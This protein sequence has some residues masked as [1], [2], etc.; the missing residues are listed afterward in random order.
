MGLEVKVIARIDADT[1]RQFHHAMLDEGITF[2]GWLRRQIGEYLLR[3]E[4]LKKKDEPRTTSAGLWTHGNEFF[5]TAEYIPEGKRRLS[6]PC[7]YLLSHS[8]ELT[9]KAFLRAKGY[10]VPELIEIG[11]DLVGLLRRAEVRGIR[12]I[13]VLEKRHLDAIAISNAIY[14]EKEWEYRKRGFKQYPIIDDL[15]SCAKALLDGTSGECTGRRVQ[16][17]SNKGKEED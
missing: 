14:K 4:R 11:H 12:G 2:S 8:I 7:Y 6:S 10:T 16:T 17:A 1:R 13:V 15:H 3:L 5:Q 9:L